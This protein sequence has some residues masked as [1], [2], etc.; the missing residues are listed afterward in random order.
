MDSIE[1][2]NKKI[3][4]SE[5]LV[6]ERYLFYISFICPVKLSATSLGKFFFISDNWRNAFRGFGTQ[7]GDSV[8]VYDIFRKSC[9]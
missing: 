5:A 3:P 7:T 2:R 8:A 4:F 1:S 9:H 6:S